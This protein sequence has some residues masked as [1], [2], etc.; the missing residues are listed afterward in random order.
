MSFLKT[1]AAFT[2]LSMGTLTYSAPAQ[3]NANDAI[4]AGAAGFAVGTL[5]GSAAARPRYYAPRAVYVAPRPVYLRRPSPLSSVGRLLLRQIPQLRPRDRPLFRLR[6]SIPPLSPVKPS[7]GDMTG[8]AFGP[9]PFFCDPHFPLRHPLTHR[10]LRIDARRRRSLTLP[11]RLY[12]VG[13]RETT[14]G[15]DGPLHRSRPALPGRDRSAGGGEP[16]RALFRRARRAS[17]PA[18]RASPTRRGPAA[19]SPASSSATPTR[20][21]CVRPAASRS[22]SA[23]R[24]PAPTSFSPAKPAA[25]RSDRSPAARP[26]A[27]AANSRWRRRATG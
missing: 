16:L 15:G 27:T 20:R 8:P 26:R 3:A 18:M 19:A 21:I 14:E 7:R 24:S 12:E 9:A 6:R 17:R 4:I 22:P 1:I 2:A 5:F 25:P 10:C 13:C 23:S 11:P